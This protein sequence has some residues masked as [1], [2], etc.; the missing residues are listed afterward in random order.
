MHLTKY[1]CQFVPGLRLQLP[2]GVCN[3]QDGSKKVMK[4]MVD[5]RRGHCHAKLGSVDQSGCTGLFL[6]AVPQAGWGNGTRAM[7]LGLLMDKK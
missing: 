7:G 1:W 5:T 6:G 4:M 2:N 3:C